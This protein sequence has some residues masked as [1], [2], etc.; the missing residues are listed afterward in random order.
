MFRIRSTSI[1]GGFL[2][3]QGGGGLQLQDSSNL[4]LQATPARNLFTGVSDNLIPHAQLDNLR[5]DFTALGVFSRLI[6]KIINTPLYENITTDVAIGIILDKVGWP[7]LERNL[8]T[9]LT[10]LRYFWADNQDAWQLLLLILAA[11]GIW[12]SIYPDGDGNFVFENRDAWQTQTRSTVSQETFSDMD[13]RV[14]DLEYDPNY[15]DLI[16]GC[17]VTA[18]EREAAPIDEIWGY[19]ETPIVMG[20]SETKRIKFHTSEPFKN[21]VDP[22]L[23]GTNAEQLLSPSVALADGSFIAVVNNADTD[24][25]AW[26]ENDILVIQAAFD[27]AVG[28]GNSFCTGTVATGIR[29][30][31]IG[32]L[33]GQKIPPITIKSSLNVGSAPATLECVYDGDGTNSVYKVFA[34]MPLSAGAFAFRVLSQTTL[35]INWNASDITIEGRFIALAQIDPGEASVSGGNVNDDVL[36]VT[37]DP[38]F[39]VIDLR[40]VNATSLRTATAATATMNVTELVMGNGPD[41]VISSGDITSITIVDINATS[42]VVKIVASAS[43]LTGAGLRVR[44]QSL[45][46]VRTHQFTYPED[47]STVQANGGQIYRPSVWQDIPVNFAES[48]PQTIVLYYGESR[49][50]ARVMTKTSIYDVNNDSLYQRQIGDLVTVVNAHLGISEDYLIMKISYELVGLDLIGRYG[51]ERAIASPPM[52]HV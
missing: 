19:G 35:P 34:P 43:G 37:F 51:C 23:V 48:Y 29:V 39:G 26:G 44:G 21:V 11:E 12:A 24:P 46:V 25:I 52:F 47:L 20:A 50:V 15:K 6:G 30:K 31:F 41:F 28:A 8:Q 36:T 32:T 18:T 42:A 5:V 40:V 13:V 14:Q 45:P 22:S 16:Q 4:S 3:L 17:E 1:S 27:T 10:T 49:P 33:A 2:A 9:G 7:A 38:S